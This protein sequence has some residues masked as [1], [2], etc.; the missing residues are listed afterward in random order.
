MLLVPLEP[1]SHIVTHAVP[2]TVAP[3]VGCV[4]KT[5]SVPVPGGGGG[6]GA[7]FCTVTEREAVAVAPLPPTAPSRHQ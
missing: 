4:M 3:D 1:S 6:G 2:R 7:A 5:L